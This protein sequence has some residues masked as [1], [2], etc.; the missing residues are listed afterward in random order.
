MNT[1]EEET[2]ILF[3]HNSQKILQSIDAHLKQHHLL[4]LAWYDVLLELQKA[5][6]GKLRF[7]SIGERV[8]LSSSNI[9]RLVD[10]LEARKYVKREVCTEDARGVY[11]VITPEGKKRLEETWPLY[12]S[13]IEEL[14]VSKFNQQDIQ[15]FNA[16][17]QK[18]RHAIPEEQ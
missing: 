7:K 18:L 12:K 9:K 10:R 5:P 14:F 8:L 13:C 1:I 3:I 4:P 16:L 11:A 6:E 17:L 2:W 15:S